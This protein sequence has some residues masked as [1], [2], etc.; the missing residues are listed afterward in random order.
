MLLVT[1]VPLWLVKMSAVQNF[2]LQYPHQISW[3]LIQTE[4]GLESV[5]SVSNSVMFTN[6]VV[7]LWQHVECTQIILNKK[8]M[9]IRA[10]RQSVNQISRKYKIHTK[11][12][13]LHLKK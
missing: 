8:S 5:E 9:S 11:M 13:S 12:Q 1:P 6:V 4:L 3:K 2:Y 10:G 7:V